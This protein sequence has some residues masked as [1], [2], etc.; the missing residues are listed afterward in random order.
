MWNICKD[1]KLHLWSLEDFEFFFIGT[2][3]LLLNYTPPLLHH[4]ESPPAGS[5]CGKPCAPFCVISFSRLSIFTVF[6]QV[7]GGMRPSHKRMPTKLCVMVEAGTDHPGVPANFNPV[8]LLSKLLQFLVSL[9]I[10]SGILMIS[11][12]ST[13][14]ATSNFR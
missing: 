7:A 10:Q 5:S 3:T 2:Y 11:R 12:R 13:S 1:V 14:T 8:E 4:F 6:Q 9:P